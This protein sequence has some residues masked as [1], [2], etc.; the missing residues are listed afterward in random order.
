MIRCVNIDWLECYCLEDAIGYPHDAEYFRQKGWEVKEREYGTPMYEEMFTLYDHFSEPFVEIRRR[1]KSVDVK[2]HGLFSQYACHV[3]LCNRS[4]YANTAAKN[5]ADFLAD[6]GF[7]FQRISRIDICYDFERFDFGDEPQKFLQRFMQGRYSKINQANINAHGLDQWDGRVWNSLSWGSPKS[8][9]K[10]R[11]YNK[12]MELRQGKDKPYIRQAWQ[13]CG[14]VDDFTTLEKRRRDGTVYKPEIWRVEF[15]IKSGTK[16]WFV[17]EDYQGDR[18]RIISKKNTLDVY[19]SRKQIFNVFLSL[20][21]HYFHFK[22]VEYKSKKNTATSAA[23]SAII[24]DPMSPFA[25]KQNDAN[26]ELQRKDRC[27]DK[28]LFRQSELDEFYRIEKLATHSPKDDTLDTL[29]RRLYAYRE[30]QYDSKI[31]DA[32][33]IIIEKIENERSIIALSSPFDET[34]IELLRRVIND[35]LHNHDVP[36]SITLDQQRHIMEIEQKIWTNPF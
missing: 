25:T 32:C 22:Y 27:K 30:R 4:C 16:N 35:R 28:Q 12:T 31:K 17:V 26:R 7:A 11:F 34:E 19:Y 2:S 9:I 36:L 18:K 13:Q 33:N 5:M 21:S 29:L 15:A 10:T 20:C 1:P 24:V 23:L 6:N 14:Y 8:M 3:R